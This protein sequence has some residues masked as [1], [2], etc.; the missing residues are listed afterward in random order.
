MAGGCSWTRNWLQFD[1]SYYKRI[2]E[3]LASN[4]PSSPAPATTL[5]SLSSDSTEGV[6]GSDELLWL[7][8]DWALYQSSEFRPHFLRYARD[9][10]AFFEDYSSAHKKMSEL[11]ARWSTSEG[12]K[13]PHI[14]IDKY[15]NK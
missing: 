10:N 2:E 12:V 13:L 9:Q 6:D 11:G 15:I 5:S 14:D 3:L 4:N 7:S 8:T 1:N